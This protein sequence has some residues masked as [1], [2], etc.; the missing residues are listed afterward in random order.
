MDYL[1][2]I[3]DTECDRP[4]EDESQLLVRMAVLRQLR[5]RVDFDLRGIL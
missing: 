1:L 5:Q 4:L 3:A 2:F